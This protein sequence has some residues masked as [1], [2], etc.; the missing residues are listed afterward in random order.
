MLFAIADCNSGVP[1]KTISTKYG[2]LY[3]TL[4]MHWKNGTSIAQ[5]GRFRKSI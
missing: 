2:L 4:Y 1:V 3:A 5:I